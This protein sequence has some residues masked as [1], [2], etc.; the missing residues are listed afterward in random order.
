MFFFSDAKANLTKIGFIGLGNM[1]SPM[2][3]NVLSK[4]ITVCRLQFKL[5]Y[6]IRLKSE[7]VRALWCH[8]MKVCGNIVM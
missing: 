6:F 2:A 1:G 3:R 5:Q 8:I 4:V 7:T